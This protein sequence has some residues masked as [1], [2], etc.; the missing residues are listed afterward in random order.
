MERILVV[1]D[2]PDTLELIKRILKEQGYRIVTAGG[3]GEAL[4]ILG[5]SE[6]DLVITDIKMPGA[7]G[8]ELLRHIKENY[9][10]IGVLL[11]TGFPALEDAVKGIKIGAEEYLVKPFTDAEL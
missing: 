5:S 9:R 6:L 7:D 1:D 4:E 3:V 8:F 10:D 11:V 2:S